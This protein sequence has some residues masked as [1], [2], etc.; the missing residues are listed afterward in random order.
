MNQVVFVCDH[1][2]AKSLIAAEYFTRL[3]AQRG[4]TLEGAAA[5]LDPYGEV[6]APVISGLA[7]RGIDVSGYTPKPVTPETYTNAP[8][9]VHF[10]CDVSA[11][12]PEGARIEDWGDVPAVSD[13]FERAHDIIAQR[14]A[15][16]VAAIADG[17]Y[18]VK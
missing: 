9:V 11:G 18:S 7:T 16:L 15:Q 3:A 8:I 14:V 1:G 13:G 10:G 12:I 17:K 5:G 2:S 6:P 4:L